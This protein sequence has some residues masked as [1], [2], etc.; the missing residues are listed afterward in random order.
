M[1]DQTSEGALLAAARELFT[2]KGFANTSVREICEGAGVTPPSLYYHFG[3]KAGLFEAVIEETIQLDDFCRLLR[4]AV[5]R[6]ADPWDKLQVFVRTYLGAFPIVTLNPGLHLGDSAQLSDT[7]LRLFGL[8]LE[9][10]Y[11]LAR[12]ILGA[13]VVAGVFREVEIETTAACLLGMVDS[14]VR[15]R[16]YLGVEYDLEQVAHSIVDL[17]ADGL[18]AS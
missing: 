6:V 3:S 11:H 1:T 14:F 8:G 7:S 10:T 18:R 12:E 15:S 4:D 17:L 13:G 2:S 16:A 9:A 5:E